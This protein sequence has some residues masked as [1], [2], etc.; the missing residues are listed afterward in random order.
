MASPNDPFLRTEGIAAINGPAS[1]NAVLLDG[2]ASANF[3]GVWVP[4]LFVKQGSLEITGTAT[5]YTLSLLGTNAVSP[6]NSYAIT[7]AGSSTAADVI[8]LTF[9]LPMGTLVAAFTVLGGNTAT[10]NAAGLVAAIGA[11]QAFAAQG[12]Q[13]SNLAGVITVTWPSIT[14]SSS[15]G[16]YTTSNPGLIQV[17]TVSSSVSGSATETVAVAP[18]TGGSLLPTANPST[19][20]ITNAAIANGTSG[21][22][23]L[24]FMVQ[25]SASARWLK[26]RVTVLSGGNI[27][28]IAQGTA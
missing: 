12:I 24:P 23:T 21:F 17:I 20:A 4:W 14:P 1:I 3:E 15:G 22:G 5:S 8:T 9:S 19:G 28:A 10:Q 11:N 7:I 2:V 13:A 6:L 27:T 25:F 16:A 26:I 18:G